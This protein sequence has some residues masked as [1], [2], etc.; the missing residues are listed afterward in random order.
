MSK[1]NERWLDKQIGRPAEEDLRSERGARSILPNHGPHA[2]G[3]DEPLDE[4]RAERR[5]IIQEHRECAEEMGVTWAEYCRLMQEHDDHQ[6]YLQSAEYAAKRRAENEMRERQQQENRAIDAQ[7]AQVA[8]AHFGN[9]T[10]LYI[11]YFGDGEEAI[12]IVRQRI[13]GKPKACKICVATL[14]VQ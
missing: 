5:R 12:A 7:V 3:D 1:D 14:T 9:V 8:F 6:E 10:P 13:G 2:Y 11:N 4:F